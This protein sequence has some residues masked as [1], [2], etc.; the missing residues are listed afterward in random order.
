[1][2]FMTVS[3]LDSLWMPEGFEWQKAAR[4]IPPGFSCICFSVLEF[5]FLRRPA[6]EIH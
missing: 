2:N 1:M 4:N 5:H 3:F 6:H